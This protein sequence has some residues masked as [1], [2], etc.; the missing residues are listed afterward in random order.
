MGET[1]WTLFSNTAN[2]PLL[3]ANFFSMEVIGE[4]LISEHYDP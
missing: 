4:P 3:H 1:A 2:R